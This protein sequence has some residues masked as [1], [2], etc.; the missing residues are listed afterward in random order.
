MASSEPLPPARS[1]LSQPIASTSTG[2]AH[3]FGTIP[4]LPSERSVHRPVL[5]KFAPGKPTVTSSPGPSQ[6]VPRT[7]LYHR[8]KREQ[9][10]ERS[11]GS[12]KRKYERKSSFNCCK[13]CHQPKTKE[14]GHSRH[15]GQH[16]LD[17]F[18]P[19]VEGRLFPSKDAWLAA[20]KRENPPRGSGGGSV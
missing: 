4:N 1:L 13:H 15:I 11:E 18:C 7:T 3:D 16:G 6:P 20:R 12:A 8:R 19:A 2:T 5:P 14:Y 17:T 10:E 9:E